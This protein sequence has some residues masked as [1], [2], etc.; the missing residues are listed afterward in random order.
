MMTRMLILALSVAVGT[1]PAIAAPAAESS[2]AA[3]R[4]VDLDLA[5]ANDRERLDTRLKNTAN[6]I[7]SSNM[8]GVAEA[9]LRSQC[10][11]AALA[12]VRPQVERA[13]AQAQGGAQLALLMVRPTR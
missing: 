12:Q 5:R 4:T 6:R 3:V 9:E 8:R 11:S 13:I 7:C 1:A 10:V 2:V